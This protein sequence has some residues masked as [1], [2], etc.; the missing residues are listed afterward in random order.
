[1][2]IISDADLTAQ[3]VKAIEQA[4]S[5]HTVVEISV[6]DRAKYVVMGV[7]QYKHLCEC[8]RECE[9]DAALAR[10]KADL[11]AG[12]FIKE[13]VAEHLARLD[14]DDSAAHNSFR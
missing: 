6:R 10:T 14:R 5:R 8:L 7:D 4:M 12:R 1:M 2:T 3:G 9:L 13:S 11:Q